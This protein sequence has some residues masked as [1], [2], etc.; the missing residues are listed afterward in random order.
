MNVI[1][2]P[3]PPSLNN[4]FF[5]VPRVGRVKTPRYQAWLADAACVL[6]Q[7]PWE[8]INGSFRARIYLSQPDRRRRDLDG[9]AKAPLDL[10]VAAGV[11]EDDRHAK[12]ILLCWTDAPPKKPGSLRIEVEAA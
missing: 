11:I 3:F 5:N 9:L 4:L 7:Q 2:L 1:T 8:A 6:G 10:L 12:S